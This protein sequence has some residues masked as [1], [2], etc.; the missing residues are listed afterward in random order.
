MRNALAAIDF[1]DSIA[2]DVAAVVVNDDDD[3]EDGGVDD[4]GIEDCAVDGIFI[5]C[6]EWPSECGMFL[7]RPFVQL[8]G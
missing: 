1:D 8:P 5:C 6:F 2:G 3:E 7:M 4:A